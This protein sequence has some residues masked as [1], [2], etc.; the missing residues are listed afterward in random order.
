MPP[1]RSATSSGAGQPAASKPAITSSGVG[2]SAA[3]K[4][5]ITSASRP[6]SSGVEKLMADVR[7]HAR[8]EPAAFTRVEKLMADVRNLGYWPVRHKPSQDLKCEAERLLAL[9]VSKMKA[10]GCLPFAALDELKGF[11]AEHRRAQDTFKAE[12]QES[13]VEAVMAELREFGRWPQQL[14]APSK[15]PKREAERLLAQRVAKMEAAACLPLAVAEELETFK[16][17]L[18]A[19]HQESKVEAVMAELR[20]FGRWPQQLHAPSGDPKREAERLLAQRVAKMKAAA[21]LTPAVIEELDA[22]EAAHRH[23]KETLEVQRRDSQVEDM[24]TQVMALSRWPLRRRPPR[25]SK[26]EAEHQ[27]AGRVR[28]AM[29]SGPLSKANSALL[30][31]MRWVHRREQEAKQLDTHQRR[32]PTRRQLA[33]C[34]ALKR[35]SR[36]RMLLQKLGQSTKRC[37]CHDFDCWAPLWKIDAAL[38]SDLRAGGFHFYDCALAPMMVSV[39]EFGTS[40]GQA[41]IRYQDHLSF[42]RVLRRMWQARMRASM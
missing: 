33:R 14:H 28:T 8:G 41:T 22:S 4:P 21:S 23:S 39:A 18:K 9:R 24:I 27:L 3:S 34:Q 6:Q 5:A 16:L 1:K 35:A 37:T 10:E 40:G 13:K 2:Q 30:D 36:M 25:S 29:R 26:Q 32:L 17:S 12:H 7:I 11:E 19:E 31:E 38:A 42:F 15:D 20:E